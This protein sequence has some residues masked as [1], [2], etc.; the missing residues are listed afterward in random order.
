MLFETWAAYLHSKEKETKKLSH[1]N[2]V[3]TPHGHD[4]MADIFKCALF[5]EISLFWLK[6]LS[7]F[8]HKG[9]IDDKL[10]LFQ[11]MV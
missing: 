1:W 5:N 3:V 10:S 8:T 9:Q 7:K 6:I 11:A 2:L 4:K